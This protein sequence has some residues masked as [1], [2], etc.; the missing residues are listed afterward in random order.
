MSKAPNTRREAFD[1]AM[2]QARNPSRD[3]TNYCQMFVRM[4]WGIPALY[5]SAYAQWLG[6]DD[7]AKHVGGDIDEVP[8]GAGLCFKGSNPAGHIDLAA[9]PFKSGSSAAWSNDL[10]TVGDI[11]KVHRNAPLRAWG[12]RYLGW[13]EE[14]N[15]YEIDL[16]NNKPPKPKQN[17][18][19]LAVDRAI[20]RMERALHTAQNQH[21]HHDI[22]LLKKEITHLHKLYAELRHH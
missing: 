3:W 2:H 9:N 22:K 12:Q 16:K 5:G 8:A 1:F 4:S 11:D 6:A 10:V 15:G 21:D 17:K 19:Y 7:S 18:R 14:I 13:L 20:N